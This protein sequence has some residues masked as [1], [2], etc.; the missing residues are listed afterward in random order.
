MSL[1]I[2]HSVRCIRDENQPAFRELEICG[3]TEEGADD[4]DLIPRT[5]NNRLRHLSI[6]PS[7]RSLMSSSFI[8]PSI[9]AGS[10]ISINL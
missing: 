4:R 9:V 1:S 6:K 8:K 2:S 5:I 7:K 10:P 3:V